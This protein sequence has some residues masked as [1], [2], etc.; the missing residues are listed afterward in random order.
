[1]DRAN[2]RLTQNGLSMGL[3]EKSVETYFNGMINTA[4]ILGATREQAEMELKKSLDFEIELASV[5][6]FQIITKKIE[7]FKKFC[8]FNYC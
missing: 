8:D 7:I 6:V 3:K 1:M 4:E 2:L 5:S